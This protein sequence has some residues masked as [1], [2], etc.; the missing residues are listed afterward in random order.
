MVTGGSPGQVG[1]DMVRT[2][3]FQL[4]EHSRKSAA[5]GHVAS[6]CDPVPSRLLRP[7]RERDHVG[8]K[9]NEGKY[10]Y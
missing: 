5:T 10:E 7:R 8:N 4:E 6:H 1:K 9:V 2:R 3:T